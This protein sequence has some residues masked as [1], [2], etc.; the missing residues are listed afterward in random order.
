M[1]N[2][3]T[4]KMMDRRLSDKKA[5]ILLGARQTGKTTFLKKYLKGKKDCLWWNG[6]NSDIRKILKEPN[7]SM[8]KR[9]I[10]RSK[11][12]IIDEAQRI[13]DIGI[14]IK[15]IIDEIPSVKVIATGSS[16]FELAGKLNEPLT[17]RKWEFKMFPLSYA[18]MIDHHAYLEEK[19]MFE[20]RMV[21]GYY[22]EVV[23]SPGEEK[24]VLEELINSSLYKDILNLDKIL[25]PQA[26]EKLVQALAFQIG[27][28]VSYS[29]L[30]QITGLDNQTVEKYIDLLEKAFIIFR[31]NSFSRNLRNELKK[32]RKIYFYDN[33]LRNAVIRQFGPIHLR[34]DMGE[35]WENFMISERQK[36]LEQNRVYV[37]KFFWRTKDQQ[38]IDYIEELNGHFDLFEFKWNPRR[39]ARLPGSFKQAYP[40][41]SFS[42]VT[43]ENHDTFV[44][45]EIV[46]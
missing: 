19:R 10:G 35:L 42:V 7:T 20:Q 40:N 6:D 18:E 1:V 9:L 37:N 2:R 5:L 14:C 23:S 13:E 16:S 30:G 36:H 22:P 46:K 41:H 29:E 28:Q 8:L 32:S 11:F 12:L 26:L 3:R 15:L 21:Y 31:L 45:D 4:A 38:E 25:K 24:E 44:L 34:Q 39:K 33:G 43:P 27:H 17:G